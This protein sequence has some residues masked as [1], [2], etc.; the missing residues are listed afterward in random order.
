[1]REANE[2]AEDRWKSHDEV[3]NEMRIPGQSILGFFLCEPVELLVSD[4][5][6][7]PQNR[8]REGAPSLAHS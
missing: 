5:D 7:P 4:V 3:L 2:E 6:R 1:M 8:G